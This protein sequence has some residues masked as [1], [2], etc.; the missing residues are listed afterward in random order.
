M[1]GW[2]NEFCFLFYRQKK[3]TKKPMGKQRQ[4]NTPKVMQSVNQK[5]EGQ[6]GDYM[7]FPGQLC[8]I[9]KAPPSLFSL[10]RST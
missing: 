5:I 9:R 2:R 10:V 1:G 7:W 4:S 6:T 3:N 8:L